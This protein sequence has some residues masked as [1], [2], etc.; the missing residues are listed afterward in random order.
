MRA[1]HG[2]RV[3]GRA[4][5]PHPD[6]DTRVTVACTFPRAWRTFG[7]APRR[8]GPA[9]LLRVSCAPSA[10]FALGA[11]VL[12]LATLRR[13]ARDPRTTP[14]ARRA[15]NRWRRARRERGER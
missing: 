6:G 1:P 13:A 9:V 8:A 7:R 11:E 10:R 4:V 2:A 5:L 15:L 14:N 3:Y 12:P